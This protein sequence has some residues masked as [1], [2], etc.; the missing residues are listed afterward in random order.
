MDKSIKADEKLLLNFNN[1]TYLFIPLS[2]NKFIYNIFK[3]T[4]YKNL[5]L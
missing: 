3:T 1:I 4:M 2:Y 5:A